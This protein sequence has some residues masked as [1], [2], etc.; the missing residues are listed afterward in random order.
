LEYLQG[1]TTSA[2]YARVSTKDKGQST[3][4]QLPELR[5][6]AQAYGYAVYKEYVEHESGSLKKLSFLF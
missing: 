4:N 3:E 1:M 6:F 2:L 5:R